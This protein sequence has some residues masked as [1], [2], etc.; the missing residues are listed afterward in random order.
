M[1]KALETLSGIAPATQKELGRCAPTNES[2][3]GLA[4]SA[5][6]GSRLQAAPTNES[7]AGLAAAPSPPVASMAGSDL[8]SYRPRGGCQFSCGSSG[9]SGF[10]A[11][12]RKN[13]W[14]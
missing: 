3:G 8:V 1:S 9:S 14:Q 2:G 5:Q 6:R 10:S 13:V 4:A 7:G 11:K 12:K